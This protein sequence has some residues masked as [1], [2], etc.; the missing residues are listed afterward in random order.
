MKY[1]YK[2]F[3]SN[4]EIDSFFNEINNHIYIP[5]DCW[6]KQDELKLYGYFYDEEKKLILPIY[7]FALDKQY[8]QIPY[9][10]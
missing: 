6:Y 1:A 5:V 4:V 8:V 2:S 10:H 7:Y 3:Q 9:H